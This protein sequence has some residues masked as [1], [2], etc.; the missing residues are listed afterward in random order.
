MRIMVVCN[1]RHHSRS[2]LALAEQLAIMG[3]QGEVIALCEPSEMGYYESFINPMTTRIVPFAEGGVEARPDVPAMAQRQAEPSTRFE[4]AYSSIARLRSRSRSAVVK[5]LIDIVRESSPGCL[6]QEKRAL[7]HYRSQIALAERLMAK[8]MP[9]VILAFGDRHIDFEVAVLAAARRRGIRVVLPYSTYSGSAGLLKLRKLQGELGIWSPFSLYRLN[10]KRVLRSQ[11]MEGYFWQ[12]PSVLMALRKLGLL[13]RNPWCIGN[14]PSDIVC[15]DNDSTFARYAAEGVPQHKIKIV[16][17]TAYD[18]LF[19]Q[20]TARY[21]V[22]A[23][24]AEEGHIRVDWPVIVIAL[25]Q[26]AEQGVMGWEEHW[27][28]IEYLLG[29]I[30]CCGPN[31]VVSLHPRVNQ[32]DYRYLEEKY[33]LHIA[34]QP[35]KDILP[36]ADVFVAV[37]SS[38]VFWAVLCGIPV[39][40]LD[41]F[42]LDSSLFNHLTSI[43]YVRDRR[44]VRDVVSIAITSSGPDFADDWKRLSRERVFDGNVIRRYFGLVGE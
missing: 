7:R 38:T 44:A 29:E 13:S 26:F 36:V 40:V 35:L 20:F 30:C 19:A 23:Q 3:L 25:P 5:K 9:T 15:V 41:Y 37:N 24:M 31:V 16:G 11:V 28:E 32:D 18:A 8:T 21:Q 4:R 12:R 22:R 39:V 10:A 6:I 17:D 33:P 14:G 43:S 34:T 1:S 2:T 42:G 27:R